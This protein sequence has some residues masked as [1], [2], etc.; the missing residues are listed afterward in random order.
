MSIAPAI[1]KHYPYG[2]LLVVAES[3]CGKT[4]GIVLR[5]LC[6]AQCVIGES[7]ALTA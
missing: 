6:R 5:A 7:E 2:P 4:H 3:G 1:L